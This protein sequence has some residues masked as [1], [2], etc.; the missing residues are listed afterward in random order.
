[1]SDGPVLTVKNLPQ[2]LVYSSATAHEAL[3]IP[4][5]GI[6]FL[7]EM[8]RIEMAYIQAALRRTNG[9]K[10]AAAALLHIDRQQLKYLCRKYKIA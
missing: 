10:V 8:A 6:N 2:Q 1:M 9:K 5:Q 7:Q 4:E 3:L